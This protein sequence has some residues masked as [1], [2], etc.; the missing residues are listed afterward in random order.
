MTSRTLLAGGH[1]RIFIP[2]YD[3]GMNNERNWIVR[4]IRFHGT[5][6]PATMG[7]PEV[8]AFLAGLQKT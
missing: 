6:H 4:F 2:V 8:K 1:S 7:E 5:R 3:G